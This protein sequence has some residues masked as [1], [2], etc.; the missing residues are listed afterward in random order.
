MKANVSH[1]MAR[2][3]AQSDAASQVSDYYSERAESYKFAVEPAPTQA[4]A[5]AD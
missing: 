5:K 1:G 2:K 4:A 3:A